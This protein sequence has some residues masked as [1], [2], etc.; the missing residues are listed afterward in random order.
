MNSRPDCSIP[1]EYVRRYVAIFGRSCHVERATPEFPRAL[2]GIRP[3]TNCR[4]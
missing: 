4:T 2:S 3:D 1:M